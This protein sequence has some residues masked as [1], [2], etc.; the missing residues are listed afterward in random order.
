[1]IDFH[2]I[3]IVSGLKN[4]KEKNM[5]VFHMPGHKQNKGLIKELEYIRENMFDFD[6]TEIE[7]TDN[8]HSPDGIIREG[9]ELLAKSMK[10][11]KSYYLVN[12][13]TCGVYSMMLGLFNRGDKVIIQRNCHKSVYSAIELGDLIPAYIYPKVVD[14]FGILS[15]IDYQELSNIIEENSDAKGLVITSP[16]YFGTCSDIENISKLCKK[17]D[18]LLLVDEAHG[19]HFSFSEMLPSPAISLGADVSVTSFHKTL[20]SLTQTAVLNVS[21]SLSDKQ[22]AKIEEKMKIFQTTSPSYLFLASMDMARY[23]MDKDGEGLTAN[24]IGMIDDLKESLKDIKQIRFL[25]ENDINEERI[26]PTRIV[27]NTPVDGEKLSDILREK[28]QIQIEMSY[29]NNI[30]LIGSPLDLKESYERLSSALREI[31]SDF[32]YSDIK[33]NEKIKLYNFH[34]IVKM[35]Q[36]DVESKDTIGINLADSESFICAETIVPYPPGV[37]IILPGEQITR[38]IIDFIIENNILEKN[39]IRSSSLSSAKIK[40]IRENKN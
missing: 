17:N 35:T 6:I 31:F 27:I 15:G 3:P 20:P 39:V 16:S 19:A 9:M 32:N 22:I 12:G 18:I 7:G 28:Y 30:V 24:L 23:I 38:E 37:P 34:P 21:K 29:H 36:R 40:V 33:E 13:S 8:L 5:A 2:K 11:K 14:S 25:E 1:M 4:Y 10:S 26:D